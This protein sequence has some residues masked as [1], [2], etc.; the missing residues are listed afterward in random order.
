MTNAELMIVP[1][2]G[3]TPVGLAMTP[4]AFTRAQ[5]EAGATKIEAD[6]DAMAFIAR[7]VGVLEP[8]QKLRPQVIV[9]FDTGA[10]RSTRGNW[11]NRL[12][13][14]IGDATT[15]LYLPATQLEN[16]QPL[17]ANWMRLVS[18]AHTIG[19]AALTEIAIADWTTEGARFHAAAY[20]GGL[21]AGQRPLS[22]PP[23][24]G[25]GLGLV[26]AVTGAPAAG[27]HDRIV[28]AYYRNPGT[29]P[30]PF[31]ITYGDN[32]SSRERQD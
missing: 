29:L 5:V 18:V 8:G 2:N 12:P 27:R 13:Q 32:T 7:Q 26:R 19:A 25:I 4:A 17:T 31:I 22:L 6:V 1:P 28:E 15:G 30:Q 23:R 20:V 24:P 16:K 10:G 21:L 11:D 3:E 9:A 14:Y